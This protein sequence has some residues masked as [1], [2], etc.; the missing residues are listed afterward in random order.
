MALIE[1]VEVSKVYQTD[2]GKVVPLQG[3]NLKIAE[4]ELVA[5]MGP[6]G[7]GKST[8]LTIIG[9]LNPASEGKLL[10]DGLDVYALSSERRADFRHSYIGFVFQ[11]LQLV[12]YLTAIENV[13][14]P[15]AISKISPRERR[16]AA[17]AALERVGLG[18][19]PNRLP[20]A[21]SGGEQ[22]RVAIAR[23][24]VNN[25]PVVLA[26]EPTG[27]LDTHTGEQ[28]MAMLR[29]LADEGLAVVLV[30][31]NE[32]NVRYADRVLRMRD[33]RLER[34]EAL[35]RPLALAAFV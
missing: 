19:K 25:P 31:H 1:V 34:E 30:T 29:E 5:I 20:S 22:G 27:S 24:I 3:A 23:A 35:S 11:Q 16:R 17:Q 18:D 7:S 2:G 6:S 32:E 26:D 8:L 21:L 33:G 28:V 12:S 4:G 13:M 9:G 15:L 14:L 10:I